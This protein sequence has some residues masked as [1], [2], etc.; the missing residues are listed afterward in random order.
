[1]QFD[2]RLQ[3]GSDQVFVAVVVAEAGHDVHLLAERGDVIGGG[4]HAAGKDLAV[5]ITRRDDVFLGRLSYRQ[6]ILI[7]VDNRIADQDDAVISYR[8][9]GPQNFIETAVFTQGG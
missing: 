7:L 8:L 1:M 4:E 9:D 5:L 6:H 3:R 2:V